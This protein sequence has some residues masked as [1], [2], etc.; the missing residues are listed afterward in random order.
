MFVEP[1]FPHIRLS[2]YK[3]KEPKR[4]EK[5]NYAFSHIRL[6]SFTVDG[7]VAGKSLVEFTIH[8]HWIDFEQKKI[9]LH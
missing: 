7:E 1:F 8:F 2:K 6:V 3:Q 9:S 5:F 4:D